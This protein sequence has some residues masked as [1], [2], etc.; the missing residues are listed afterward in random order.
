MIDTSQPELV[1][2]I[3]SVRAA[4]RIAHQVQADMAVAGITKEDMSPVTVADYASQAYVGQALRTAFPGDVLVGEESSEDLK[5]PENAVLLDTIPKYVGAVTEGATPEVIC[6]WIDVG[7]E[8]P[9][10]RFW[11]LDPVDGTKGYLRGGQYAVALAL[12]VDGEVILG[13]LGCPQ[14]GLDGT[15]ESNTGAG[16]LAI[17]QRGQG[18]WVTP[19]FEE[20]E[21]TQIGVSD[22]TDAKGARLMRSVEAAHTNDG[23]IDAIANLLGVEAEPVRMDSQAKYIAM[24]AGNGEILLRLLSAKQPDYKE[25]IWDQAAG[26]ILLEEAGGTV[27]DIHGV[28]YDF[29]QG[30][31]LLKN[32]GLAASNGPLHTALLAALKEVCG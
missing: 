4:A 11:T 6:D 29:S 23:Q 14:L 21:W 10:A 3:E 20:G 31:R 8:D 7:A 5:L 9:T 27:T 15:P 24:A 18:A 25:K 22:C 19:L 2:L 12:V 1:F 13:A 16:V 32:Q 26:S 28:P 30:R 17:A